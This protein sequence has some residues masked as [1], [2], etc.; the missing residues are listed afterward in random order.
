VLCERNRE[1]LHAGA[2]FLLPTPRSWGPSKSPKD[3]QTHLICDFDKKAESLGRLEQQPAGDVLAEVLGLGAGLH[4]KS[5]G[6]AHTQLL[7]D[8]PPVP[9]C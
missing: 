2:S 1:M 9:H 3:G 8:L 4:L 6:V 5:L 7:Q